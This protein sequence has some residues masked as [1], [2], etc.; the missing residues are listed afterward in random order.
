MLGLIVPTL[1][2]AAW[3]PTRHLGA[4]VLRP[5]AA[6]DNQHQHALRRPRS[7]AE[8]LLTAAMT[9]RFPEWPQ[10]VLSGRRDLQEVIDA[11][12]SVALA[13][14]L[15]ASAEDADESW[16][17]W[18]DGGF[19]AHKFIASKLSRNTYPA[20]LALQLQLVAEC[21]LKYPALYAVL[22]VRR[23]PS[24]PPAHLPA[25][26][27]LPHADPRPRHAAA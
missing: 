8:P 9:T 22:K 4:A 16:R 21:Q 3:S 5:P 17:D 1:L 11:F 7:R 2:V 20:V 25:A 13:V 18:S 10:H 6:Y 19:T 15:D 24:A 23:R 27:A 14:P 12:G 26:R